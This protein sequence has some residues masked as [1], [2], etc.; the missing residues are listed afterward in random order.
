MIA[1]CEWNAAAL[2]KKNKTV[3]FFQ[4]SSWSN[5]N[6]GFCFIYLEIIDL[7]GHMKKAHWQK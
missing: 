2:I 6:I 1:T 7:P 3:L 4:R 5:R